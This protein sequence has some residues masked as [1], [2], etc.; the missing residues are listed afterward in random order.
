MNEIKK[1]HL[2]R[3]TFTISVDA[4]KLL[5]AYLDAIED[6][7]GSKAEVLKEIESRMAELLLERGIT[8][9]KVVLVE[10]I[11]FLK[12][13]LGDPGDFK[14]DEGQAADRAETVETPQKRLFRDTD[15]AMIAGVCSGLA[16]YFGVEV[17]IIRLIFLVTLF[18]GGAAIPVYLVLWLVMPEAKTPSDKLKMQGKAVTVDSL[19]E[20]VDRADVKGAADRATKAAGPLITRLLQ[21]VVAIIGSVFVTVAMV[22]FVGLAMALTYLF[23][24]RDDAIANAVA[25]PVGSAEVV[26]TAMAAIVVA[27]FSFLLLFGGMSMVNRRWSLPGWVTATLIFLMLAAGGVGTA[28]GPDTV[29]GVSDRYRDA[30]QVSMDRSKAFSSVL[31]SDAHVDVV[32]ERSDKYEVGVR[33]VGKEKPV[34]LAYTI[35]DGQLRITD[36]SIRWNECD[37]W[38]ILPGSFEEIVVRAPKL[39]SVTTTDGRTWHNVRDGQRIDIGDYRDYSDSEE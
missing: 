27:A 38:C 30:Q 18:F 37:G 11:D 25:F 2:G 3:Q 13:Q 21:I 36:D 22:T 8:G 35:E 10:D 4:H 33:Y 15:N 14:D 23:F 20:L 12:E 29:R 9:D 32:Y 17:T 24:H 1:I 28:V 31:I 16:A 19:K 6:Q 39:E 34:D 7:V 5:K 26:F